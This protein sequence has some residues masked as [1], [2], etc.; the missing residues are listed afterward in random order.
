M[1]K[2]MLCRCLLAFILN[3]KA[4]KFSPYT[5]DIYVTAAVAVFILF[6]TS[7]LSQSFQV[8]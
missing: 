7:T 1:A 4:K 5:S 8:L 2:I 6:L 3:F